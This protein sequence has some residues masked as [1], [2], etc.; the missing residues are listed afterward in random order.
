M[1]LAGRRPADRQGGSLRSNRVHLLPPFDEF[2]VA[3][4][5]RSAVLDPAFAK[6][7][8]T[9]GGILNAIVI[10]RGRVVA[11]W[12]RVLRANA[13]EV[14]VSPFRP[15]DASEIRELAAAVDR[16]GRFLERKA[17]LAGIAWANIP[18]RTL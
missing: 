6:R 9:G 1:E 12:K 15:L 2:T 17:T 8:N 14:T 16:Y 13:V 7:V 11:T 5:D 10:A 3:Y 18:M 4:K